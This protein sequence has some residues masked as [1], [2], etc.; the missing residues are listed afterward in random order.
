MNPIKVESYTFSELSSSEIEA[1]SGGI[2]F[3]APVLIK[4][5]AFAV[6]AAFGAGGVIIITR[7]L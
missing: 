5:G 4:I 3:V 2:F 7:L 6:G 1:V